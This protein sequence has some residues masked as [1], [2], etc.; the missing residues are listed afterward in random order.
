MV[1][2]AIKHGILK[3]SKGGGIRISIFIKED[4]YRGNRKYI[5]NSHCIKTIENWFNGGFKIYL[6]NGKDIE[7]SRRQAILFKEFLSL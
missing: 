3:R 5:F 2:N 1:K 6:Q 7:I 4:F